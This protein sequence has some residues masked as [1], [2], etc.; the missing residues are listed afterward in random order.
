MIE[1]YEEVNEMLL[2]KESLMKDEQSEESKCESW[3]R[4]WE[5]ISCYVSGEE[6]ELQL[7]IKDYERK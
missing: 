3:V 2:T 1:A 4:T 7:K 6:N 5:G